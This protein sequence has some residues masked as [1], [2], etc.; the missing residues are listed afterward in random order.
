MIDT[1]WGA[2]SHCWSQRE[3]DI[4]DGSCS[5]LFGVRGQEGIFRF[6]QTKFHLFDEYPRIFSTKTSPLTT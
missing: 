3:G 6:L 5:L 2:H 1:E 4:T